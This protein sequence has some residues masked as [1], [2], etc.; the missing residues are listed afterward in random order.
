MAVPSTVL[1]F[2]AYDELKSVFGSRCEGTPAAALAPMLAGST[3][4]TATVVAVSPLELVRTQM[5]AQRTTL[6][7]VLHGLR[8][9]VAVQGA[10]SLFRGLVPTLF[11]DVPFSAVYWGGYEAIKH[12]LTP[13]APPAGADGIRP[14]IS[15]DELYVDDGVDTFFRAFAAGAGSGMFAA[16]ITTPFDV[17]KTRAQ[18]VLYESAA[19]RTVPEPGSRPAVQP[20]SAS[21]MFRALSQ[22]W[23][24]EGAG[25]LF[26]GGT[27]RIAK[28]APACAIMIGSYEYSKAFFSTT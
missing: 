11:R 14:P 16:A 12:A 2:T 7:G 23:R 20:H 28:V 26:T 25:G 6:R 18:A 17:V 13:T 15:E 21:A 10:G 24:V 9:Q 5:Q 22:I 27:A 1:Y 19:G 4:R 3:A 8:A